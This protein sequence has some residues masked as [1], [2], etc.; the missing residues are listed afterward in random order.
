MLTFLCNKL[1]FI[2]FFSH[3]KKISQILESLARKWKTLEQNGLT[4][5]ATWLKERESITH[6]S[7]FSYLKLFCGPL[8]FELSKFHFI[9]TIH[10]CMVS[11]TFV[12]GLPPRL[13]RPPV[14]QSVPPGMRPGM[15]QSNVLSAPP[16]IMKPS[17]PQQQV[18][19][20]SDWS[21]DFTVSISL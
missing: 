8:Q 1:N 15:V 11:N 12:T 4:T 16:S 13:V 19:S 2:V 3:E 10:C 17:Q 6:N 9:F 21:L 7:N 5:V 20:P 18:C 14:V